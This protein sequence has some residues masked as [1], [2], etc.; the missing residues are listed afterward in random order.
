MAAKSTGRMSQSNVSTPEGAPATAGALVIVA[1]LRLRCAPG[2][3]P[4]CSPQRVVASARVRAALGQRAR[5]RLQDGPLPMSGASR[6][7]RVR[8]TANK[9]RHPEP[10]IEQ[11]GLCVKTSTSILT[12]GTVRASPR[13][14]AASAN[15]IDPGRR[16]SQPEFRRAEG[17]VTHIRRLRSTRHSADAGGGR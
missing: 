4:R 11:G 16:R 12:R 5:W 7:V 14:D 3:R 8:H 10:R 2:S 15:A 9:C 6:D 13:S 17:V 1:T